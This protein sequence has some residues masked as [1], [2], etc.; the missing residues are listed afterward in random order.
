M[1][2]FCCNKIISLRKLNKNDYENHSINKHFA[3]N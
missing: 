2:N 3:D 1:L